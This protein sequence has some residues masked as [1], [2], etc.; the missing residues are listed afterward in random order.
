MS[1]L[2][3]SATQ[4]VKAIVN[5]DEQVSTAWFL[6]SAVEWKLVFKR[7]DGLFEHIGRFLNQ[8]DSFKRVSL[9]F[10]RADISH[11]ELCWTGCSPVE[12]HT[13]ETDEWD[14]DEHATVNFEARGLFKSCNDLLLCVRTTR[15]DL[16]PKRD[17]DVLFWNGFLKKRDYQARWVQSEVGVG[18]GYEPGRFLRCAHQHHDHDPSTAADAPPYTYVNVA[19]HQYSSGYTVNI[20]HNVLRIMQPVRIHALM[21]TDTRDIQTVDPSPAPSPAVDGPVTHF[22]KPPIA[23]ATMRFYYNDMS[24]FTIDNQTWLHVDLPVHQME[25][26]FFKTVALA[27]D[28]R[29]VQSYNVA[30]KLSFDLRDAT[31]G[32]RTWRFADDI[33]YFQC[34]VMRKI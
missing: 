10:K 30:M 17:V 12:S 29:E 7:A 14:A 9:T 31:P 28:E 15:G 23:A 3:P 18:F 2:Y 8:A 16:Y 27:E 11:A 32:T 20:L 24:L 13:I 33:F 1:V 19:V 6:S 21:L 4:A 25:A 26:G 34:G 22:R 5:K